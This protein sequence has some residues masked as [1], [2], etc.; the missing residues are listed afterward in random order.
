MA[1]NSKANG[2]KR[3]DPVT[4]RVPKRTYQP[5]RKELREKMDMPGLSRRQA[6]KLFARPFKFTSD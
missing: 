5:T 4:M 1:V 3:P 6:R 2:D